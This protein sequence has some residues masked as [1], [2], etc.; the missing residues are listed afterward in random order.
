MAK[1]T[2]I[3][4]DVFRI[5]TY[6]PEFDLQF[7]QFLVRDR[8]P[9]LFHAGMRAMFPDI[10][11]AVATLIDPS[12]LR[13]ISFSHFEPDECGAL[14]EWLKLAPAAQAVTTVVGA[15]VFI[16]DFA[17]RPPRPLTEDETFSTGSHRFRL[18][19][20]QHLPHGWDAGMLFE[21]TNR[22]LFC[23]DLFH[24]AGDV[25]PATE[26]DVVGRFRETIT[27][28]QSTPLMD[29]LPYTP[30]TKHHVE[31]LAALKPKTCAAMHGSA[32]IGDGERALNELHGV[33]KEVYG[34]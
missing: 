33:L 20:T 7:C 27:Q 2:E 15:V 4:P 16:S 25:E 13:W 21:E 17:I 1:V 26:N 10:K 23:S 5:S 9:L 28:Y 19:T 31:R 12:S 3:A 11:E 24:Q 6:V 34:S 14:N 8:E 18:L 30:K 22:T 32:F 29:Y